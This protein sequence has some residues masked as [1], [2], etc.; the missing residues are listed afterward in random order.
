MRVLCKRVSATQESGRII[1]YY[2]L[3]LVV[4]PGFSGLSGSSETGGYRTFWVW[5][6]GLLFPVN[7]FQGLGD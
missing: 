1:I 6:I 2:Y 4:I 7:S 5:L 3:L